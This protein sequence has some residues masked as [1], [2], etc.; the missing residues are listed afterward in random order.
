[1]FVIRRA[2][3]DDVRRFFSGKFESRIR[4]DYV[5]QELDDVPDGF[6]VPTGRSKPWGTAHAMLA[7]RDVVDSPFAV[8]NGDDFYGRSALAR[9]AEYLETLRVDDSDY[10]MVGYRLDKTLSLHGSVSR[11]IVSTDDDD[12]LTSIRE[13]TKLSPRDGRVASYGEDDLI[14]EWL[15]GTEATSMNLFGF[16]PFAMRQFE[17]EFSAFLESNTDDIKAEFYIPYAMNRLQ[18]AGT[19]RMRVLRSDSEWFG[20]TYQEDRETVVRRIAELVAQ[21]VYP[22]SLWG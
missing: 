16:T 10:A 1:M 12:W 6:S 19:A 7:A 13:H 18:N 5:Y 20:V 14:L 21:G 3:E 22:S 9:I 8:I 4:I 11:G 15:S 17:S 2:I